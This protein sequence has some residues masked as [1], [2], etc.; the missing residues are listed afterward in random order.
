M[1]RYTRGNTGA[2]VK[3]RHFAPLDATYPAMVAQLR[4]ERFVFERTRKDHECELRFAGGSI[5]RTDSRVGSTIRKTQS[6]SLCLGRDS[7]NS[8][9]SQA[10]L[11]ESIIE[12][13]ALGAHSRDSGATPMRN[14]TLRDSAQR[15]V[16]LALQMAN[17]ESGAYSKVRDHSK[18][19]LRRAIRRLERDSVLLHS[20]Q[21]TSA[22]AE[23]CRRR[24]ANQLHTQKSPWWHPTPF[25]SPR[26]TASCALPPQ[27]PSSLP[28]F[29]PAAHAL[30]VPLFT[31]GTVLPS[32]GLANGPSAVL[33]DRFASLRAGGR[34]M[35][36]EGTWNER[37]GG[38]TENP[39]YHRKRTR[40]RRSLLFAAVASIFF[41]ASPVFTRAVVLAVSHRALYNRLMRAECPRRLVSRPAGW[42]GGCAKIALNGKRVNLIKRFD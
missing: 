32:R 21:P 10:I 9:K 36:G 40:G 17:R 30:S 1:R 6:L 27:P 22:S 39:R 24:R 2:P 8:L 11:A 25:R 4:N 5:A 13:S 3:R 34:E 37:E 38:R 16:S 18:H 35:S 15:S 19:R 7:A 20:N 29:P 14:A 42:P 26:P 41:H 33:S 31:R 23:R 12:G 28:I